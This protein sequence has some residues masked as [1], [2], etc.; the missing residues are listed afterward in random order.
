MVRRLQ[1]RHYIFAYIISR[2]DGDNNSALAGVPHRPTLPKIP[3]PFPFRIP[4]TQAAELES[5]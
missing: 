4:D 1:L 3:V 5:E 2:R